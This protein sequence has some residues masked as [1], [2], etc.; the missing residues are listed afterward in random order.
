MQVRRG[1]LERRVRLQAALHEHPACAAPLEPRVAGRRR[2]GAHDAAGLDLVDVRHRRPDF[3]REQ[4][5]HAG[6]RGRRDADDRVQPGRGCGWSVRRRPDS[7]PNSRLHRRWEITTARGATGAVV[8][9]QQRASDSRADAEQLEVVAGDGLAHREARA[10]GQL[11]RGDRRAVAQHVGEHL[12]LRLEVE[13]VRIGA[14]RVLV[15]VTAAREHVNESVGRSTGSGRNSRASTIVNSAVLN[16]MPRASEA[17]A[18]EGERRAAAEPAQGKP[19]IREQV[20][21]HG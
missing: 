1:A 3:G 12:V 2:D 15:A 7:P 20:F 17:I 6:E 5:H 13:E 11:H 16:P 21:E 14:R 8:L 4:R 19:D 9:G 10:I 18:T